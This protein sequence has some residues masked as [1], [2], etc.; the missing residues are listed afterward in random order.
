MNQKERKRIEELEAQLE[1][2]T[3]QAV[4]SEQLA[5]T[6]LVIAERAHPGVLTRY[7]EALGQDLSGPELIKA[8]RAY[9]VARLRE[10]QSATAGEEHRDHNRRGLA[11]AA[12]VGELQR[13]GGAGGD[14]RIDAE[15]MPSGAS[16][17]Y[18][19]DGVLDVGALADAM[20]R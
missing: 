4:A 2:T 1:R 7:I 3:R 17:R 13:Q 12:L 16:H 18:N 5:A 19:I 9:T 20:P 6:A 10:L 15:P 11:I 8:T 14:L